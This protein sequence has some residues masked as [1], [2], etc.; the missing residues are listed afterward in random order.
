MGDS[1]AGRG[2][3]K[4]DADGSKVC[5]API[6]IVVERVIGTP[7]G[8]KRSERRQRDEKNRS[9]QK[10]MYTPPARTIPAVREGFRME[11]SDEERVKVVIARKKDKIP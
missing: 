1:R 6:R 2:D 9:Q 3:E 10:P 5:R 7:D 8:V 11:M 4:A